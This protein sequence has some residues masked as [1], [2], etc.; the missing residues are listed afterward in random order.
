MLLR[1]S[2]TALRH[3]LPVFPIMSHNEIDIII[4]FDFILYIYIRPLVN[5]LLVKDRSLTSIF[6]VPPF[7]FQTLVFQ[8][9]LIFEKHIDFH[10]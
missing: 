6:W 8:R 3:T 9:S 7:C 5:I 1:E 10:K 4:P 2:P